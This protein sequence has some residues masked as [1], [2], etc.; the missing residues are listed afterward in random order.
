MRRITNATVKIDGKTYLMSI[1]VGLCGVKAIH[2]GEQL[3][4]EHEL[5]DGKLVSKI[6]VDWS[7]LTAL[8]SFQ[9]WLIDLRR[10][11]FKQRRKKHRNCCSLRF[12]IYDPFISLFRARQRPVRKG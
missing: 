4:T 6:R 5:F 8:E 1:E 2:F 10:Y 3:K 7:N 9:M 12:I 11:L